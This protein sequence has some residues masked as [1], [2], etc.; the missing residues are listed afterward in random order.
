MTTHVLALARKL[1][2]RPVPRRS[3]SAP[4]ATVLTIATT[5]FVAATVATASP[6]EAGLSVRSCPSALAPSSAPLYEVANSQIGVWLRGEPVKD[7]SNKEYGPVD[8]DD[9]RLLG[10]T[11]GDPMG[12][13][14]NKVWNYVQLADGR[15]GYLP[16][17]YA[18][19]PTVANQFLNGVPRCDAVPAQQ[20]PP[21]SSYNRTAA[22]KWA[23]DNAKSKPPNGISCTWFV[24]NAMWAGGLKKTTEWTSEGS[25]RPSRSRPWMTHPGTVVAWAAPNLLDYLRRTYPAS[26]Y[27]ELNFTTNEV[28]AAQVGDIIAYDWEG[29]GTI[30]H[31]ALVVNIASGSYPEVAEW[32]ASGD[33]AASYSKRGW[34]WSEVRKEW[35]QVKYPKVKAHL[36]HVAA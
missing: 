36:L 4:R 9:F 22:V 10:Q 24:S 13:R 17:A 30:D 35:L 20:A 16:D 7:T 31:L 19:T 26:T 14:A 3:R 21:P 12:T 34:T 8:G 29:D 25:Y 27:T 15:Y 32:S 1:P 5:A 23:T 11:S 18:S 6:A 33:S 28:Q 2:D